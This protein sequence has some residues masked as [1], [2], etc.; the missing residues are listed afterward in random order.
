MKVM[1]AARMATPDL[2]RSMAYVARLLT[3]WTDEHDK[4]LHR[5]V[6]YIKNSLAYL[7]YAWNDRPCFGGYFCAASIF[8]R[9]LRRLLADATVHYGG[10]GI[11]D[12]QG[13][14]YTNFLVARATELRLQI[15]V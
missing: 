10:R 1:Y 8:G 3:K 4:R 14:Q 6:A 12:T 9:R 11:S 7:M 2:L 13:C 5:L 15:Y